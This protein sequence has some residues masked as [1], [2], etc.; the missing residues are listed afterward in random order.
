MLTK[1]IFI[2]GLLAIALALVCSAQTP[3][4]NFNYGSGNISP[5]RLIGGPYAAG[6]RT[7]TVSQG[8]T[9]ANGIML[10]PLATNALIRVGS[11]TSQESV[12]P[13]AVTCTTPAVYG[14]CTFTATF[15]YAHGTGDLVASATVGLQEAIN[16]TA[17]QGGGT[18]SVDRSWTRAGGTTAIISA[19]RPSSQVS[20]L[21][22]RN[23]SNTQW[24]GM[25]PTALTSLAAPATLDATSATWTAAPVG[26]WT[27][28]AHY[29]CVTY[30]DALGG[31]GPCS[32]TYDVTPT[33]TYTLHIAS[34]AA[35][36]GAV[37]WRA[38]AGASYN[39]ANLLP[40]T[41]SNC[42]LTTLESVMPACAIGANGTWTAIFTTTSTL[43]PNAQSPTVNLKLPFPQGHTTFAYVPMAQAPVP[44][45]THY[46]AFPAFGNTTAGQVDV[47][48]SFNLPA[49]YLNV[50]GRTLR[51]SGKI[52]LGTVNTATLPTLSIAIAW[53]GGTT[54]G[55]PTNVCVFSGPAVGSTVVYN[56]PFECTLT[57]NAVGTTAVGKLMPAGSASVQVPT[58]AAVGQAYTEQGVATVDTL[59]LFAQDTFYVVYTSTT[60]ATS[61]PQ[62]LDLHVET[63]Q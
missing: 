44:F 47:L 61:A 50:I 22:M 49:G 33:A 15:T 52:T 4:L 38:Y 23:V 40:I 57:T 30:V 31:E 32:A 27:N 9:N 51:V 14:T 28:A 24:W 37:G 34:P 62:L 25:Q 18:V 19:L 26:T 63:V 13:S 1:R 6:A 55:A 21:D 8:Y 2:A 12:T 42:T 36:T 5:L 16:Y 17:A 60:N 41:S 45:Q 46:G 11:G 3:A 43:R 20:I 29:L 10:S 53:A 7:V 39:A 56:M 58:G 48:G 54:A 35:S 59:G